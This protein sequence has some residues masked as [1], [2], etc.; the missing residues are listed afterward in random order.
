MPRKDI[1]G[2]FRAPNLS[3]SSDPPI[4]LVS[5]NKHAHDNEKTAESDHMLEASRIAARYE[6]G[7]GCSSNANRRNDCRRIGMAGWPRLPSNWN[8]HSLSRRVRRIN[9]LSRH[10]LTRSRRTTFQFGCYDFSTLP[11]LRSTSCQSAHG[12]LW[13]AST[14]YLLPVPASRLGR[15]CASILVGREDDFDGIFGC[16]MR[17]ARSS[18]QDARF[19]E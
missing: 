19:H 6:L 15:I 14:V 2:S 9:F 5:H 18:M 10:R 13:S 8:N 4:A 12:I 17:V 11:A 1:R 7:T 16:C 3:S